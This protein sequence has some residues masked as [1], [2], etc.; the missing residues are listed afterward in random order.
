VTLSR[1]AGPWCEI[2]G[3]LLM[4]RAIPNGVASG[5][6]PLKLGLAALIWLCLS[7]PG[8]RAQRMDELLTPSTTYRD[9]FSSLDLKRPSLAGVRKAVRRGDA[10]AAVAALAAYFR[11]RQSPRGL[12]P[13]KPEAA[14]TSSSELIAEAERILAH[15]L[16]SVGIEHQFGPEIDWHYN[17][18]YEPDSPFDRDN[19]WTWQLNRHHMWET[20]ARAY[21]LTG[22]ERYAEEFVRQMMHWIR[23]CPVPRGEADQRPFSTWRTIEA[24]IRMAYSWPETFFSFVNSP[25]FTDQALVT[26]VASFA[27][28][29]RYLRSFPTRGNWL[30][31]EMDGL[32]H[33]GLLFP[34]FRESTEW[35]QFAVE[36]LFAELDRQVYP[37]GAQIELTPGYHD[38]ALRNFLRPLQ[39]ASRNGQKLP[40]GYLQRLERMFAFLLW[41]STPDGDVPRFNDAWSVDV[42]ERLAEGARL[43]PERRDFLW[44]ATR[45]RE[46]TMPDHRSHLFPFAGI[47]VM[48]SDWTREANYLA[49]DAGPF[50]FGHQHEDKLS[51]VL[52]L[53]GVPFIVDAGSYAYDA[54]KWRR[55]VLSARGHNVVHVDGKEQKRRGKPREAYVVDRPVPLVWKS[56]DRFDYLEAAYGGPDELFEDSLRARHTRRVLYLRGSRSEKDLWVILDSLEPF[57]DRPHSY[58]SVFHLDVPQVEVRQDQ[59]LL[60]ATKA[61]VTMEMR[62]ARLPGLA[63]RVVEGQEEPVV[64]GWMP[65][66]HGRR[67]VRAIPTPHFE[68]ER[69]GSFHL[70]YL[71]STAGEEVGVRILSFDWAADRWDRPA[72]DIRLADGSTLTIQWEID[73][74]PAWESGGWARSRRVSVERR[75]ASGA[76]ESIQVLP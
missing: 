56:A 15:R 24:G 69:S 32:F 22:E 23:S 30:T 36:T 57:D 73:P 55:Y 72:L 6:L 39:L 65:L 60:R 28:H 70:G 20:L 68:I 35:R 48:R 76:R 12:L 21:R 38:V 50:G 33:V 4:P 47:A 51:F 2:N 75:S 1:V 58:T 18:T 19:E 64:Q 46:G 25:N 61:G 34:E 66:A 11:D 31:M 26:M 17:P 9:F 27:E 53:R 54:S 49:L 44:L 52:Y 62:W 5:I 40:D 43:F 74:P 67:G 45:G 16:S 37:D 13:A 71:I 63:V 14:S 41:I 8:A 3:G 10:K 7:G 59:A 42:P 29:A